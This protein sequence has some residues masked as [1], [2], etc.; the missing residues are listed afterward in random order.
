[1]CSFK[2]E[3]Q[4]SQNYKGNWTC[5]GCCWHWQGCGWNTWQ[6]EQNYQVLSV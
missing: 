5:H 1:L 2:N 3:E 6:F 4:L